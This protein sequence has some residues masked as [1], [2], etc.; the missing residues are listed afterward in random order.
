MKEERSAETPLWR[1]AK[2]HLPNVPV[3]ED[4]IA[5]ICKHGAIE[6]GCKYCAGEELGK[7]LSHLKAVERPRKKLSR[8]DLRLLEPKLF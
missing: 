5:G 2:R 3:G 4:L 7:E 8:A 1:V 6:G